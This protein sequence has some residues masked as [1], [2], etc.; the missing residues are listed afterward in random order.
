MN[1]GGT[2]LDGRLGSQPP[3]NNWNNPGPGQGL[4]RSRKGKRNNCFFCFQASQRRLG[5]IYNRAGA[6]KQGVL[7]AFLD[8][9]E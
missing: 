5:R 8:K 4:H 7:V 2:A 1:Q 3:P 9:Q 6:T